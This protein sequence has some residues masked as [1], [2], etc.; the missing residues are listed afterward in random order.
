M[1]DDDVFFLRRRR[2]GTDSAL[3]RNWQ[4]EAKKIYRSSEVVDAT[5]IFAWLSNFIADGRISNSKVPSR[6][7][8][9]NRKILDELHFSVSQ[10]INGINFGGRKTVP[11]RTVSWKRKRPLQSKR[12]PETRWWDSDETDFRWTGGYFRFE[13]E[14]T[15]TGKRWESNLK[16]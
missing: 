16:K 11:V 9:C 13:S 10:K 1:A 3:T 12:N 2:R 5:V 15:W 6:T 7:V 8:L 4:L 14:S